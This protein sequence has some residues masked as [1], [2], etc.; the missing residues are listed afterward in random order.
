MN[1]LLVEDNQTIVKGLEYAFESNGYTF[2]G[3]GTI[4]EALHCLD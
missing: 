2:Y 3:V 1:I 4:R